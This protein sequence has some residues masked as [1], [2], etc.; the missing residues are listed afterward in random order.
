VVQRTRSEGLDEAR[1]YGDSSTAAIAHDGKAGLCEIATNGS[2]PNK[3][4]HS[5]PW[6]RHGRQN[7]VCK[8]LATTP[9]AH[10]FAKP[11]RTTI[12][13]LAS[14]SLI[15]V[16]GCKQSLHGFRRQYVPRD[17]M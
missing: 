7:P 16:H 5:R 15:D 14:R 10:D 13:R 17:I 6:M 9:C 11:T 8:A 3:S 2:R 4:V 12:R 1:W